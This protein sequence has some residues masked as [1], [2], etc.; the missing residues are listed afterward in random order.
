MVGRHLRLLSFV[1]VEELLGRFANVGAAIGVEDWEL[2]VERARRLRLYQCHGL[3]IGSSREGGSSVVGVSDVTRGSQQCGTPADLECEG[4]LVPAASR[5]D[6]VLRPETCS[7][8]TSTCDSGS[9]VLA[10]WAGWVSSHRNHGTV[11]ISRR[12]GNKHG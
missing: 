11:F 4:G 7:P 9:Y 2:G 3:K 10:G 1:G 12:T 8:G 6:P 5:R